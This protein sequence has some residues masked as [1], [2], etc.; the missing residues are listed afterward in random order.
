MIV[1]TLARRRSAW[2]ADTGRQSAAI[3]SRVRLARNLADE[4]FP[5]HADA[6]NRK[7]LFGKLSKAVLATGLLESPEVIDLQDASEADLQVLMERRLITAELA[8]RGPGAG[9]V[10]S[11]DESLAVMI[12][13]E[14]HLRIQAIHSGMGLEAAWERAN[15]LDSALEAQLVYAFSPEWGYLT[16][17]PSNIG[18][19][20]RA[21]VM[22]HL[23]GL[24]LSND[25]D[26]T[27]K[28]LDRLN[29]AVRGVSGEG[30]D[31]AGHM[32][33]VS[34]QETL[35]CSETEIIESLSQLVEE[36]VRQEHNA[37]MRLMEDAPHIVVDCVA[38]ALALLRHARIM[39][40]DEAQDL[41]SALRLGIELGVVSRLSVAGVNALLLLS[42]PGH[43]QNRLDVTL[44]PDQRD[45]ARAVQIS[46][47]LSGVL[48]H[49]IEVANHS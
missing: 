36:A 43:L 19:G 4:R 9:L 45:Q 40:S 14:D 31:A 22:L 29:L 15:A 20:L 18:T 35:G 26:P 46:T 39:P 24:R 42:Q 12:N 41:L 2:L 6:E 21:S 28:A 16:A 27:L 5:D 37:R 17:C 8:E 10:L 30:S 3:S 38:R 23:L 1:S 49:D 11:A 25:L 47:R 44:T 48:V 7:R 13:E 34:N 32:F 33:Q